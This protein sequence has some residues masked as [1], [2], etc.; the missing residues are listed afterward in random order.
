MVAY[1]YYKLWR[2]EEKGLGKGKGMGMGKG[3]HRFCGRAIFSGV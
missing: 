1:Q 3:A 2:G